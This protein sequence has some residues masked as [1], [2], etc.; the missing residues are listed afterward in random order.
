MARLRR[1]KRL[2]WW[3]V[4]KR[5]V[6]EFQDDNLTDWAAALTYYGVMSLFPMVLVLVALLGVVGQYPQTSDAILRIVDRIGPASAVDTFR[7]PIEGVVRT[8]GG[9]GALLGVGLLASLWSASGYIGAFMRACNAVYEVREGRSFW[10][11]RPLQVVVTLVLVVLITGVAI[12]IVISGPITRA[13]GDEIG[14]GNA[15]VT[16]FNIAKW[17]V[18]VL[19]LLVIVGVLY[20][21][22]PNVRQPSF[23][24]ITPGA[25][26]AIVVWAAASFGLAFYAAQ[27]GS[28]QKTY[29]TLGGVILFLV[30]L[31]ISNLALLLGAELNAELE[32]GRELA[33]GLPAEKE[34]QLPP[35]AEPSS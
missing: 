14:M 18:I 34:I 33:A 2:R 22:S 17:P 9:S 6:K 28:Y 4:L 8:K 35:R 23:P 25:V 26:L 1:E 19:V 15:A 13:V 24:W 12:A 7:Q 5:T 20:Y 30:W 21:V 10:K 29:G 32:R 3:A 16:I 11:R 27:F 31:W